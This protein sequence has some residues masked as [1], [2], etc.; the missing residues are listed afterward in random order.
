VLRERL[1]DLFRRVDG[2]EAAIGDLK[3]LSPGDAGRKMPPA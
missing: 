1:P 3:K 2:L